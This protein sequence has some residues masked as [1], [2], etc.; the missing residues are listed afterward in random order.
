MTSKTKVNKEGD[1]SSAPLKVLILVTGDKGGTGKSTFARGLLDVLTHHGVKVAA[2]DGDRRNA[3]L[4]RHYRSLEGGVT[5]LDVM[6]TGGSD[7]LLDDM[8]SEVAPVMLVDLPAGAG[9]ALEEFEKETGFLEGAT[10]LGY[11]V[12]LVSVLSPVRDSVNALRVLMEE[13][14]EQAAYVAVK[15]LHFGSDV[16]FEVF[17]ES[18]AKQELLRRE[19]LI[20]SMPKLFGE[21]FSLVDNKSLT[22]RQA[23]QVLVMSQR[24]RVYQW[25]DA[26]DRELVKAGPILGFEP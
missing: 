8:E 19:G 1:S 22:F 17:D 16:Q 6:E 10:E 14:G 26:L 7:R 23:S 11:Q 4:F 3:Q 13:M 15:N 12:S 18:K 9:A 21:T 24:R 5:Q 2:Y 20:L 25:L